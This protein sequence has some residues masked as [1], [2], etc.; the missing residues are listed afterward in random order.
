MKSIIYYRDDSKDAHELERSIR[1]YL[2]GKGVDVVSISSRD[3]P[4]SLDAGTR[5]DAF[6]LSIGGDGTFL[7]AADT[8]RRRD[9]CR[10]R[11]HEPCHP[12]CAAALSRA[13]AEM[14][15]ARSEC[16]TVRGSSA[17]R[18]TAVGESPG[19]NT[20]TENR[21]NPL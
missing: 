14:I 2:T 17:R 9:G 1:P 20:I 15:A 4:S 11:Q 19:R 8:G 3:E 5:E 18:R 12:S 10:T 21:A 13:H 7:R 16:D 6:I